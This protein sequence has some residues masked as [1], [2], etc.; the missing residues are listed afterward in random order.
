VTQLMQELAKASQ[1]TSDAS[2]QVS[3]SLSQTVAVT[4]QLQESVDAFKVG[5]EV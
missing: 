5:T 2:H 1:H 3:G 4:Q